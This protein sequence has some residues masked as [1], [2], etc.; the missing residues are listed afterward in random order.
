LP[1]DVSNDP[2]E[3]ENCDPQGWYGEESLDVEA[4]HAMAPG[5]HVLYVGGEDCFDE[6]LIEAVNKIVDGNLA[7]IITNSYGNYGEAEDA[8]LLQAWNDTFRQA[9]LEG[10]G[11]YFS[12]GDNGDEIANIGFASPDF[13]ASH[14]LVTAVG[15]TS[16]GV[17]KDDNYL[18]QTGWGTTTTTL[19]SGAWAPAPPGDYLYGAGGGT[20][21]L[22][23]EP[24][25]QKPV[26]PK[27][28][29][30]ANHGKGGGRVVPDVSL[31]GD[32]Q[33]GML[34]GQTQTFPDGTVRY[35]EYRLGGTSLSSP[36]MA[37]VMALADQRAGRRHGFANPALYE[38]YG[39]TAYRDVVAPVSPIAVVRNDFVNSVD[40]TE[41]TT[42]K[43][44]TFDQTGTLHTTPGYDDV[45][46]VG[47]PNGQ[48]FLDA[49]AFRAG[50]WGWGRGAA[51]ARRPGWAGGAGR[52]AGA[53]GLLARRP[54]R[55]PTA[56][57]PRRPPTAWR[58]RRPPTAW[59]PRRRATAWRPRRPPTAWRPRRPPTAW[60][61]RRPPTAWRP[62]RRRA[63]R[64]PRR[65]APLSAHASGRVLAM[66]ERI[67]GLVVL[68]RVRLAAERASLAAPCPA[69]GRTSWDR[70]RFPAVVPGGSRTAPDQ[71]RFPG[72]I[73]R[74]SALRRPRDPAQ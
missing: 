35:S 18:F 57:R 33:T 30:N 59:R 14:P 70:V 46:G 16:L 63:A 11:M 47:T 32:P 10:I 1:P 23:A 29:A 8:A 40:A 28:L 22:F 7:Q 3:I 73:Q 41:G 17:G 39:T 34:V 20:S 5:A 48:Q 58:P 49:L 72:P 25:Y 54:R 21:R 68:S 64:G 62:R 71:P 61:P 52:R 60:R 50:R 12:S 31:V 27:K 4:V 53:A 15:G 2:D 26:V 38:R 19:I 45:T 13:P 37:G 42:T 69:G 44:R 55:R 51:C 9:A 67:Q 56:R 65:R 66:R 24:D 36:L 43:L 6:N 74:S